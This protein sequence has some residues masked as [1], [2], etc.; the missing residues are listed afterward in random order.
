MLTRAYWEHRQCV[1]DVSATFLY[2]D[3][4]YFI[5]CSPTVLRCSALCGDISDDS[6]RCPNLRTAKASRGLKS[7]VGP[8]I[9]QRMIKTLQIGLQ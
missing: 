6:L 1:D 3:V 8:C 2:L 7:P 9:M 4:G 5:E